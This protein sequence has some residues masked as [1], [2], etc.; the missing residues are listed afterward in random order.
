MRKTK[1]PIPADTEFYACPLC[2]FI[3]TDKNAMINHLVDIHNLK[4]K[5]AKALVET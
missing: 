2:K 3:T 5:N 4:R 1:T